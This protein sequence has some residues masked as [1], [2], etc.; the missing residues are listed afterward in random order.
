MENKKIDEVKEKLRGKTTIGLHV[1]F[2]PRRDGDASWEGEVE[3]EVSVILD[4]G[5]KHFIQKIKGKEGNYYRHCYYTLDNNERR[6]VF[7]QFASTIPEE[8]YKKLIK[9]AVKKWV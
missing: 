4:N 1:N 5:D 3:D 8:L 6:I 2:L 9:E 7:G